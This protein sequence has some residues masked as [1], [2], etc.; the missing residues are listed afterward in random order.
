MTST[1][2]TSLLKKHIGVNRIHIVRANIE[3]ID[4]EE[5]IVLDVANHKKDQCC[6]PICGKKAPKYDLGRTKG[7]WRALDMGSTKV[8]LRAD[9]QRVECRKHGVH[10]QKVSWARQGSRFTYN[11]EEI[12]AWLT[13]H[14][15]RTAVAEYMRISWNTVGP[16]LTRIEKELSAKSENKFDNLVRIGID[17][18][19]FKKGHKYITVVVN[20]D[21]GSVVW[22]GEGH[23][24][25]T[26]SKFFELLTEE[27]RK[28]IKLVSAD[29]A[30]WIT[31]TMRKYCPDAERCIDPFHVVSWAQ[32][33]LDK[34]KNTAVAEARKEMLA[35][36]PKKQRG[37]PAAGVETE[38]EEEKAYKTIKGSKYALL[39]NPENLT[40]NQ[41]ARLEMILLNNPKLAKAYRLKEELRLIFKLPLDEVPEAIYKWRHKAWTSRIPEFVAFHKKIK[42]HEQ[43]ILATMKN[44]LSNARIEA[45]NNKIKLSIRMAYGFRNIENL[46]ST[47]MLRCGGLVIKLP[48]R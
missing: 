32:D 42:R 45:I 21:T 35:N 20:H 38:T 4:S 44:G 5:A 30:R 40:D 9:T 41:K 24:E 22:V 7:I 14:L 36:K 33:I 29:G 10:T 31:S 23:S 28:S 6:C 3:T 17:E 8:Y 48:G 19:S 2:I 18:T 16:I 37:R 27:Q 15:P 46:F 1:A 34:L 25:D 39:K 47:I 11:F 43:A 13:L 26:L 12:V